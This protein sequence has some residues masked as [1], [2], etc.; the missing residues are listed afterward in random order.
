M[1]FL[2]WWLVNTLGTTLLLFAASTLLA[3]VLNP[4]VVRL[5]RRG[6]RRGLA[7]LTLV[8]ATLALLGLAGWLLAPALL[9]I[10]AAAGRLA[11]GET[12]VAK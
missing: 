4:L 5:E 10:H 11:A 3:M 9:D 8:A 12:D 7:V 2:A 6:L 1:L